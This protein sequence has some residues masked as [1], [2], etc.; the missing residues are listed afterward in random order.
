MGCGGMVSKA[1]FGALALAGF[2]WLLLVGI[3][4]TGGTDA[5]TRLNLQKAGSLKHMEMLE[6]REKEKPVDLN[7]M[8]K[9]RIPNGPDPIHNRTHMRVVLLPTVTS[10]F[11][12]QV[13]KVPLISKFN[14]NYDS[15][16]NWTPTNWGE[17]GPCLKN[18]IVIA[19][20]NI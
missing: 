7:Y 1:L 20:E 15:S 16:H 14:E 13:L 6:G 8:S 5:T 2:F 10:I 18:G 3:L 12:F 9:R 11:M 4:E 17:A 19:H